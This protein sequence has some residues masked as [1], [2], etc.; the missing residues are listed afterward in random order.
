MKSEDDM[1]KKDGGG[2]GGM[3]HRSKDGA[4]SISS[5]L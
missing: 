2:G 5:E 4:A 1:V 3:K